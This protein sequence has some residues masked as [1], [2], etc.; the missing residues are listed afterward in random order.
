MAASYFAACKKMVASLEAL[1]A[2]DRAHPSAALSH[3]QHARR[4]KLLEEAVERVHFVIIQ[5]EA[6][7]LSGGDQFFQDYAIPEEVKKRL[8]PKRKK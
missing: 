5:R 4:S 3:A 6:L 8:G 1:K 7:Q 2:F